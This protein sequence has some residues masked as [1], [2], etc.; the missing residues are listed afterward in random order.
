MLHLFE[1]RRKCVSLCYILSDLLVMRCFCRL[2]PNASF[3][4]GSHMETA[5]I[6]SDVFRYMFAGSFSNPKIKRKHRKRASSMYQVWDQRL[7]ATGQPG[8]WQTHWVGPI[9]TG[10]FSGLSL[11]L[12]QNLL[13][14]WE[15]VEL[16]TE[17]KGQHT[18]LAYNI[19]ENPC[20]S[21]FIVVLL[22]SSEDLHPQWGIAHMFIRVAT[23]HD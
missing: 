6:G 21:Y 8:S 20:A 11:H 12:L 4:L 18:L 1:T 10:L 7:S 5:A 3:I 15:H 9:E 23:P 22:T 19:A 17:I 14:L 13:C 16:W 2:F